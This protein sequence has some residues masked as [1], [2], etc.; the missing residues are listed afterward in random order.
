L[1]KIDPFTLLE[2]NPDD[3]DALYDAST[4]RL[5]QLRPDEE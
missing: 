3:I 5:A 2:R 4:Q 1:F